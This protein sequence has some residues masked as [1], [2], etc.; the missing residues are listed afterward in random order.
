MEYERLRTEVDH[1][2]RLQEE[3]QRKRVEQEHDERAMAFEHCRWRWRGVTEEAATCSGQATGAV[4]GGAGASPRPCSVKGAGSAEFALGVWR[5]S[6]SIGLSVAGGQ[7]APGT[8]IVS[9]V[10]DYVAALL[11]GDVL[12]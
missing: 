4:G 6:C 7:G 9:E 5:F 8:M 10:L 2:V 1:E 11:H 12:G 3:A